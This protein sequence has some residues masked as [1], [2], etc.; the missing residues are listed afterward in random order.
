MPFQTRMAFFLLWS[1]K[2]ENLNTA[3]LDPKIMNRETEA[4]NL[5]KMAM[6][7]VH[8]EAV[9]YIPGLPRPYDNN[10]YFQYSVDFTDNLPLQ[11]TVNCSNWIIN[12]RDP[13]QSN[14]WINHSDQINDSLKF[15]HKA[16]VSHTANIYFQIFKYIS[17]YTPPPKIKIK[18]IIHKFHKYG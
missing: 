18:K 3:L 13:N 1:T 14:A 9:H 12:C 6:C 15:P 5:Q 4:F 11:C 7:V 8:M 10:T 16:I 2:W 17:K